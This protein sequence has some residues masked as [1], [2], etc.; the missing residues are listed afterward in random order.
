MNLT[1]NESIRDIVRQGI[2]GADISAL[3]QS[4]LHDPA[5][6]RDILKDTVSV[7]FPLPPHSHGYLTVLRQAYDVLSELVR[8]PQQLSREKIC[9]AQRRLID[10]CR[11]QDIEHGGYVVPGKT[12][13]ATGATVV[14]AG[15][16]VIQFCPYTIVDE[17]VDFI[18]HMAKVSNVEFP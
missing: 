10:T 1:L 17:E 18:C 7:G 2:D 12:R 11:F 14:I 16:V 9:N 6:V 5:V 8:D 3:P 13:T 15:P 4:P